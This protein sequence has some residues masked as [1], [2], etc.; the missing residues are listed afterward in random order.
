MSSD[1]LTLNS[2]FKFYMF[3]P[4]SENLS[5]KDQKRARTYSIALKIF[6]IPYLIGRLFLYDRKYVP[7]R[8]D[9]LGP[10]D[11]STQKVAAPTF[12]RTDTEKDA[13][14]AMRIEREEQEEAGRR[15]AERLAAE[16]LAQYVDDDDDALLAA[17]AFPLTS[18]RQRLHL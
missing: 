15:E 16:Q 7:L 11:A 8:K 14:L 12:S 2:F 3:H 9:D 17:E 10:T 13:E 1:R 6:F 4:N 5:P 18:P